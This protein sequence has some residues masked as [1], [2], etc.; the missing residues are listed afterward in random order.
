M[1]EYIF[2]DLARPDRAAAFLRRER[3]GVQH[4]ARMQPRIVGPGQEPTLT[5]TTQLD[6]TITAVHCQLLQ[7]EATIIQMELVSTEWDVLSWC[8]YQTWQARLPG[9]S[10]GSVVRYRITAQLS[11]GESI[12]ADDGARFSYIVGGDFRSPRWAEEAIIYQVFPDRF[13]PGAD[14]SWLRPTDLEGYFGGTINGIIESLDYIVDLGFNCVWLNPFFPDDTYHGYH[15]TDY[16]QVNPRLGTLDD[17]RRLVAESHK[18]GIRLLL[19]YVANHW[20]SEH[21]YFREAQAARDSQYHEWFYFNEWPHDYETYYSV[22]ELPKINVDH[23]PARQHL[24]DC[25]IYWLDEIGFDGLRIDHAHGPSLDFWTDLRLAV[26]RVKP[27]AWLFGEVTLPVRQ[28][29]VYEGR[30]HGC[31]DFLLAEALRR[32]FAFKSMGLTA[33]DAFLNQHEAAYPAQFSRPSFLD[34]HDM[35]RFAFAASADVR[36]LK[37]AALVLFTLSGPPTLYYGTEVGVGQERFINGPDGRGMAEARLPMLWGEAQDQELRQFF[38]WLVHF[39]RQHP[40]I[41]RGKR[42][43]VHLDDEAGTYA[44]TQSDGEATVVVALNTSE[45]ERVFSAVGHR[46]HLSPVCG[47]I[48]EGRMG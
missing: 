39:R 26:E 19:D 37:L 35:D 24:L 32:M 11:G 8:Y 1:N 10:E 7:P 20:S 29:L 18:R 12:P 44:Y 38:R 36:R 21:S 5:V 31:L 45:Q 9:Y 43:T 23:P 22:Q 27:D 46:F 4:Q 34:N 33:F 25:A 2:G 40:V 48:R 15:A 47:E 42:Q 30:F 41:W 14:K 28:Q 6:Q 16:F 17:V 13:N 3:N